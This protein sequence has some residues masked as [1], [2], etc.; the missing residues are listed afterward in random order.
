M[1]TPLDNGSGYRNVRALVMGASGFVGRHVARHLDRSG[2]D[3]F[4]AVRHV[5][6]STELSSRLNAPTV[7]GGD[8]SRTGSVA[9]LVR[10]IRPD[11][12]FNLA[13]YG[14]D[15]SEREE[16]LYRR[17]N[18]EVVRELAEAMAELSPR[19][20]S[21]I[22]SLGR[23]V[24]HVGTALEYGV[25]KGKLD[26]DGPARPTTLY[27]RS[28]LAGTLALQQ[29][30]A[31]TDLTAVTAR[32]FSVYGPGEHDGRLLPA[33]LALRGTSDRLPLSSG[34]Q[35]RDFVF[36]EDV[37]EGLLRLGL[38]QGTPGEVV[39]LASGELTS[40]RTFIETAARVFGLNS[41]QLG[42]DEIPAADW[43]QSHDPLDLARLQER[44]GWKPT[45]SLEEGLRQTGAS[46]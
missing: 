29:V 20:S 45:T 13:G 7:C 28:K 2:A 44:T 14:I 25:A 42:F 21:A 1:S 39:N 6:S 11:I 30:C 35:L 16:E 5:S 26:E 9:D 31:R 12:V 19:P 15:K 27:G 46:D 36:V 33:L 37:A 22:P 23:R 32:L 18:T 24:V 38:S 8:L 40:V 4:L 3:L 43:E 17:I 34:G 10:E 41:D